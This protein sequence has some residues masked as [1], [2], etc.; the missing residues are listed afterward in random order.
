M[1]L[2]N[3]YVLNLF[4]LKHIERVCANRVFCKGFMGEELMK[5]IYINITIRINK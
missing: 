2:C 3:R 4:K 1:C 5:N